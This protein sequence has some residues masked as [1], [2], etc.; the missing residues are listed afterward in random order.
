MYT[1]PYSNNGTDIAA[2]PDQGFLPDAGGPCRRIIV[3]RTQIERVIID[4][5]AS[6]CARLRILGRSGRTPIQITEPMP[7]DFDQL[8]RALLD[9]HAYKGGN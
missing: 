7:D 1:Q 9:R 4:Y 5:P 3:V 2:E 8:V 6:G